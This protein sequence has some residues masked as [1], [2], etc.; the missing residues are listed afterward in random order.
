MEILRRVSPAS[1]K[2][3]MQ[4]RQ[5]TLA[6]PELGALSLK[7]KLL[8][9]IG[10]VAVLQSSRCTLVWAKQARQEGASDEE[11]VEAI[12]VARLD[13][14]RHRQRDGGGGSEPARLHPG[15]RLGSPEVTPGTR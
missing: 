9:G 10:A 6:N 2:T 3:Y 14:S 12:L 8:V 11:I 1:A 4:H 7:N 5:E 15:G 13:E